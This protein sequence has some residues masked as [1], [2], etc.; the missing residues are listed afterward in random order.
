[1]AKYTKKEKTRWLSLKFFGTTDNPHDDTNPYDDVSIFLDS[2][3]G[4]LRWGMSSEVRQR[5]KIRFADTF[6]K[7]LQLYKVEIDLADVLIGIQDDNKTNREVVD[8]W[9]AVAKFP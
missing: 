5:S 4:S 7:V 6:K 9:V 8:G 2:T 3:V 1:M